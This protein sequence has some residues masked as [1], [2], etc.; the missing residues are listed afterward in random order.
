M[1]LTQIDLL[2]K[3]KLEGQLNSSKLKKK[4]TENYKYK[5]IKNQ[6]SLGD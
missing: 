3:K 4:Y 5:I 2:K 1:N 6:Y